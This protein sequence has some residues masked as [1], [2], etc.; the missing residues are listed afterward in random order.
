MPLDNPVGLRGCASTPRGPPASNSEVNSQLLS[1]LQA[2]V[3]NSITHRPVSFNARNELGGNRGVSIWPFIVLHHFL[4]KA[5]VIPVNC[6]QTPLD[7]VAVIITLLPSQ[8]LVIVG[9]LDCIKTTKVGHACEKHKTDYHQATN[10]PRVTQHYRN[11]Y[12][13]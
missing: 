6:L 4:N 5:F 12:D 3:Y 9:H 8:K 2:W 1:N 11:P 10:K 7:L 13:E